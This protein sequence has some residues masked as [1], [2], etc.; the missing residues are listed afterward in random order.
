MCD[1]V[2]NDF[3]KY[4]LYKNICASSDCNCK[5]FNVGFFSFLFA[6]VVLSEHMFYRFFTFCTKLFLVLLIKKNL[7]IIFRAYVA[8]I[9]LLCLL[10]R[11]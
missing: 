11:L 6:V 1:S 3:V 10:A 4:Y 7:M 5:T 2:M 8:L 9:F